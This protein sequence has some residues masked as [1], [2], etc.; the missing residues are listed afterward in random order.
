MSLAPSEYF[1]RNFYVGA[2]FL[3]SS[4]SALRHDVGVGR[5]MWGAD[6]PH[7]EGSYPYTTLALRAA[8]G[9]CDPVEVVRMLE[10][11]A[12]D[13][14]GFELEALRPVGDRIGPTVAEVARPLE[15]EDYPTDSTCNA[16]DRHQVL[17]SW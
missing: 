8:F 17:R 10:T 7:S 14:Y 5:I 9:D 16:F 6:Y 3:R 15:V 12:A 11:N 2:S 4:E 13:L 1:A